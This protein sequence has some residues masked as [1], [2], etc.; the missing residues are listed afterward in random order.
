MRQGLD[1][2]LCKSVTDGKSIIIEGTLANHDLLD[3]LHCYTKHTNV[4]IVPFMLTLVDVVTHRH[5]AKEA[6][7]D[8]DEPFEKMRKYQQALI[9]TNEERQAQQQ[10]QQQHDK[11]RTFYEIRI[12]LDG[13]QNMIDTMQ[14]IVLDLIAAQ[15]S[16]NNMTTDK[17]RLVNNNTSHE[18]SKSIAFNCPTAAGSG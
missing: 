12:D 16:S 1:P 3:Y 11:K 4:I 14:S 18:S 17:P 2:D 9:D 8:A 13:V 7:L 15:I 5:L 6:Q 10:Q